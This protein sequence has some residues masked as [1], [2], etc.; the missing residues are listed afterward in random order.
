M[1]F[2]MLAPL[3]FLRCTPF[4]PFGYSVDRKRERWLIKEYERVLNELLNGLTPENHTI[5]VE[6][7]ALPERIRGFGHVK[8]AAMIETKRHEAKLMKNF[9]NASLYVSAA[10]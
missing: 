10:E 8:E 4:D 9:R 7:A 6:I 2:R 3:R 5:A 1:V